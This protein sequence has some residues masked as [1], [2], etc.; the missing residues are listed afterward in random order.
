LPVQ[1]AAKGEVV[2]SEQVDHVFGDGTVVHTIVSA[3]P[4]FDA[5]GR[6]RGAVAAISDI[7]HLKKAELAL[8][9]ADRR[10]DEFLAMLAH[11]LRNPLAPIR[12]AVELLRMRGPL[13]PDLIWGRDLIDRQVRHLGRLVD[14]LLDVSR[15]SRGKIDLRKERIPIAAIVSGA[16]EIS[17]PNI[18]ANRHELAV[19]LAAES[20]FVDADLVRMS[21]VVANLLNNAAK[22]TPP[23][24]RINLG[25][26]KDESWIIL[27][28]SDNGIGIPANMLSR[29]FEMFA[30]VKTSIERTTGGLGIGLTLVRRIV[31]VHGGTVEAF[32]P[33]VGRGSEFVV[34]LPLAKPAAP[35]DLGKTGGPALDGVL[36]RR[37]LLVDDNKDAAD[38]MALLLQMHGH[39]VRTAH[40]GIDGLKAAEEFRPEVALLDLGL[41]NLNGYE[42]AQRIR[43]Q[44]W[45]KDITL[46]AITGWGQEEDRRRSK[47]AGFDHHL[48]KPVRSAS[49]EEL[50]NGPSTE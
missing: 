26:D 10:K 13:V 9:E 8:Q 38:S 19:E 30:Q 14:D 24:G 21:Q 42:L 33:G 23:G 49:I 25:V 45:G 17:R 50:L 43:E 4:L 27:R 22:Y 40:D 16:L 35:A 31:E 28:V 1:R 12:S 34:R 15:V 5:A 41:P 11:E 36:P 2:S 7:T 6:P 48:V 47:L 44:L 39:K 29:I 37:I 3:R 20:L 18:E 46:I 32:S